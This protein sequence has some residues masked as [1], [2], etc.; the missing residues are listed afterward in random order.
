M[1]QKGMGHIQLDLQLR[2]DDARGMKPVAQEALL[3][4]QIQGIR[5]RL[6]S[7]LMRWQERLRGVSVTTN[8]SQKGVI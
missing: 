5:T 6:G 7:H 2:F 3:P 8:I 1:N 4:L